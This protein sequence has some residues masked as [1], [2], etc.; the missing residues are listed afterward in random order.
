MSLHAEPILDVPE[1]TTQV[2]RAAFPNGNIYIQLRDELGTIYEDKLFADLYPLDGQPAISPWRLALVTVI[3][4]AESL[5]DRQAA[6][7]VR[8]R[9]DLKYL[10]GLDLA[11]PG[12]DYSVLCEFRAR[13]VTGDALSLLLDRI[14]EVVGEKGLLK[15]RGRQRTD[16]THIVAAVRDLS[17]LELVGRTLLHALNSLAVA[18]PNWL[19]A[20]ALPEWLERYNIRWEEYHLPKTKAK[21]FEL[22]AQIGRDGTFLLQAIYADKSP[23]WLREIPAV[24]TLRQVWIQ[25]FYE[26]SNQ[27]RWRLAGNIPPAAKAICSPYDTEARYNI[28]RQKAWTGYKVHLTETCDPTEPHLITHVVTTE[29]TVQ[30]NEIVD[31]LHD[32]LAQKALLPNEHVVDRGYSDSDSILTAADKH[33]IDMIVP[34]RANN[35]WQQQ[36]EHG[37]GLSDFQIDWDAQQATC[38]QGKT[39]ASWVLGHD[40]R[41][42]PRNEIMFNASDCVPCQARTLCTRSKRKRRKISVSPQRH[43]E[44]LQAVR[45]FEQ[46]E[47]FKSRYATRAGI[48]G[49]ISQAVV[50]LN[51]R[52]TRYRGREKTHLQ[53]VAT[54]VAINLQRMHNWWNDLPLAQTQTSRFVRLMAA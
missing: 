10:L 37:Y 38:P 9:I 5:P 54:A 46:T 39:S 40:I 21:R 6:D 23:D 53:H 49:T 3:Q 17:R 11:D 28:K 35:S 41:G 51:M 44:L 45:E 20:I 22:G 31:D 19:K 52:R 2:A 18:A 43:F 14:L 4:F 1:L 15:S 27:L 42:N 30:D 25:N 47:A 24:D 48:E 16:S 50:A 33:Q 29:A 7:A 34:S 12:F 36:E 26:E 32:A 13:L 8:S